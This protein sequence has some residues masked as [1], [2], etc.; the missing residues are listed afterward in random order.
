MAPLPGRRGR[1]DWPQSTGT[2]GVQEAKS[3]GISDTVKSQKKPLKGN[4]C[5][6]HKAHSSLGGSRGLHFGVRHQTGT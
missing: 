4:A 6:L 2:V 3:E 5:G 1:I